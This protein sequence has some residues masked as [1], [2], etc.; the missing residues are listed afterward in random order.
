MRLLGNGRLEA[1]CF[2]GQKRLCRIRGSMRK[3]NWIKV[4]DFLLIGLRDYQNDKA[5]IIKLYSADE[6]HLL[7]SYGEFPETVK[8]NDIEEE[9]EEVTFEKSLNEEYPAGWDCSEPENSDS[10]NENF[11]VYNPNHGKVAAVVSDARGQSRDLM[12]C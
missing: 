2:D 4:G 1:Y 6:A 9:E 8:L 11:V 12:V 10:E 7:K 5:D 3:K